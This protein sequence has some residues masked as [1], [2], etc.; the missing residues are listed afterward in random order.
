MYVNI[1]IE[2]GKLWLESVNFSLSIFNAKASRSNYKSWRSLDFMNDWSVLFGA[3]IENDTYM[4]MA[5]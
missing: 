3:D 1:L 4:T 5:G 2:K